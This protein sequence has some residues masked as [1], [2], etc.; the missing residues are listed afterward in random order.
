MYSYWHLCNTSSVGIGRTVIERES[1]STLQITST[2][3]RPPCPR[4]R[5]EYNLKTLPGTAELAADPV[6]LL[7]DA[8]HP[9][10]V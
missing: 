8:R 5:A 3:S 4:V 9:L 6:L 1:G 7:S 2:I 10:V